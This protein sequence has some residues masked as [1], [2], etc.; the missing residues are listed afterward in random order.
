MVAYN[1]AI[2]LVPTST[3][4]VRVL[5]SFLFEFVPFLILDF[6][7]FLNLCVL[8]WHCS[9]MSGGSSQRQLLLTGLQWMGKMLLLG[10]IM[11]SSFLHFMIKSSCERNLSRLP[12][13]FFP[14]NFTPTWK[15]TLNCSMLEGSSL[16]CWLQINCSLLEAVCSAGYTSFRCGLI[17]GRW[18]LGL[19]FVCSLIYG[20][21][22]FFILFPVSFVQNGS[23]WGRRFVS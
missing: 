5:D 13:F 10:I 18:R 19:L 17:L 20:Q 21:T 1:R 22:I 4:V 9:L 2:T 7:F 14:P 15:T 11:W 6:F 16:Q 12:I 23:S 8:A 3:L